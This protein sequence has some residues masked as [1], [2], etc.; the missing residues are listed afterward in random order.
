VDA[1]ADR[2]ERGDAVSRR[3]P[4]RIAAYEH[5]RLD[6]Q[7]ADAVARD[8]ERDERNEC[9][10]SWDRLQEAF[11]AVDV[12]LEAGLSERERDLAAR[13]R[14]DWPWLT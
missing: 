7:H 5:A 12:D 2:R 10:E 9:A 11:G 8:D 13:Y 14:W 3:G 1:H 4:D 6:E